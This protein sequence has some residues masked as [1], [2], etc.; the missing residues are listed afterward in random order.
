[1]P[2]RLQSFVSFSHF[3][4]LPTWFR[5]LT[6][7]HRLSTLLHCQCKND[8]SLRMLLHGDFTVLITSNT[9]QLDVLGQ[10]THLSPKLLTTRFVHGH[11]FLVP[12]RMKRSRF[13]LLGRKVWNPTAKWNRT[14]CLQQVPPHCKMFENGLEQ[15]RIKTRETHDEKRWK[16]KTSPA[17]CKS[18]GSMTIYI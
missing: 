7:A 11:H 2:C 16:S 14:R 3:Q 8:P 13:W 12:R 4:L 6:V 9:S 17:K 15:Q 10:P 5:T 18:H 1:M